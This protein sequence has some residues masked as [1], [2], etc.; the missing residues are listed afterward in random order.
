MNVGVVFVF[1]VAFVVDVVLFLFCRFQL[2]PNVSIIK[3]RYSLPYALPLNCTFSDVHA[4]SV[5]IK[6]D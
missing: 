3:A 2:F 6:Y 1:V 4:W 5:R